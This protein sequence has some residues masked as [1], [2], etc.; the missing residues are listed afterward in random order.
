MTD[1]VQ[2]KYPEAIVECEWL[3]NRIRAADIRVYDCTTYLHYTDDHPLKPY[4]VESGF[5]DYK[6]AHITNSAFLDLQQ[7]F[8]DNNSLY[9]FTLPK[10]NE[11]GESFKKHGI[12]DPY[13]VILYS[14]N[15]SQWATRI[16]YMLHVLG[17]ENVSILNGGFL[18]WQKL[19]LPIESKITNFNSADFK[20]DVKS[21]IFVGKDEVLQAVSDGSTIILNALTEDLHKGLN[22]RYGRPGRIPNSVNIPFHEL[23][24]PDTGKFKS[25]SEVTQIFADKD[26]HSE[27]K[28]LNYCGGGIAATL[29]AFVLRQMGFSHIQIYD[30]SMSEWAMD[31]KLPIEVD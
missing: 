19:G 21:D 26:V 15:G 22:T 1:A 4:D 27:L 13:H 5:E 3:S 12:G 20:V 2:W 9:S 24:K 6:K 16:W 18:E 25:P 28:I 7:E 10:F 23:I 30:N 11:L 29:N 17:Y 31:E 8:S 14:R